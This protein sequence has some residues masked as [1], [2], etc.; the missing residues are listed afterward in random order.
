M[1]HVSTCQGKPCWVPTCDPQPCVLSS[2]GFRVQPRGSPFGEIY[3]WVKSVLGKSRMERW[4]L[5]DL[6]GC[7][8]RGHLAHSGVKSGTDRFP[9][10]TP[11][12]DF[13]SIN[14]WGPQKSGRRVVGI[15]F[16]FIW[17]D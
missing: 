3:S 13:D 17:A 2:P 4:Y 16:R 14:E 5:D 15:M 11:L 7:H 1:I 12:R 6:G 8:D 9:F 10:N